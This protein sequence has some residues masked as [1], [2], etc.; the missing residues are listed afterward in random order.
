MFQ[1]ALTPLKLYVFK[2]HGSFQKLTLGYQ[3]TLPS[4]KIGPGMIAMVGVRSSYTPLY[5]TVK[6]RSNLIWNVELLKYI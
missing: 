3:A 6:F 5:H 2:K 4:G 1:H